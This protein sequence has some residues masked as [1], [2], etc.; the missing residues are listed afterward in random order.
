MRA[1]GWVVRFG[2][3]R[4]RF[5]RPHFV[6][7]AIAGDGVGSVCQ[8]VVVGN[9]QYLLSGSHDKDVEHSIIVLF[10]FSW[11][12]AFVPIKYHSVP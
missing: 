3:E 12:V 10:R 4:K 8:D 2:Q 1:R 7:A 9:N 6:A 5:T 11:W